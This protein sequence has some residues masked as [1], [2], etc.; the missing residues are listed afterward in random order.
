MKKLLATVAAIGFA[1]AAQAQSEYATITKVKPN[2]ENISINVPVTQCYDVEIPIY[3]RRQ[4]HA[5]TGDTIV[6]AIIGGALGNQVG[7]GRGKD[8]ATV[9]GAIIGADVANKR[10]HSQQVITGYRN[11][12][13]CEQV[14]HYETQSRIKNY[15][16]TFEWNGTR[17]TSYTYNNY[18][19]GDRIPVIVSIVAQ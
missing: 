16:I 5:S 11:E 6:G 2:Y 9:L 1:T 10:N 7:N 3:G 15:R 18:R 8:A 13:Q 14:N 19:V 4:G 12:R 17:G